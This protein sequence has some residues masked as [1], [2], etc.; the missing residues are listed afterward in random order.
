MKV[1]DFYYILTYCWVAPE[2]FSFFCSFKFLALPSLNSK[3]RLDWHHDLFFHSRGHTSRHEKVAEVVFGDINL[4]FYLH[5]FILLPTYST[6]P[7]RS[8]MIKLLRPHWSHKGDHNLFLAFHRRQ[9][10]LT[11]GTSHL[12]TSRVLLTNP[13]ECSLNTDYRYNFSSIHFSRT[14]V[15]SLIFDFWAFTILN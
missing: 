14:V 5:V 4:H 15:I 3:Y 2:D 1:V 11:R 8:P 13:L 7:V 6:F 12:Q 9:L 10:L